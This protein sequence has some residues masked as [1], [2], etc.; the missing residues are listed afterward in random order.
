MK[1]I[2]AKVSLLATLLFCP[3]AF[4]AGSL[5]N[6]VT[7]GTTLNIS[8][9]IPNHLYPNAGIKVNT[10]GYSL[11][12]GCRPTANGYC[13]FPASNTTPAN[14]SINGVAGN[15]ALTLC[16]NGLGPLSC[17]NY[18]TVIGSATPPVIPMH[19]IAY[20]T[21]PAN[22]T[23]SI[24]PVSADGASLGT[25]TLST[26]SGTLN[27]PGF[28][29]FNAAKTYAYITN[30]NNN[31]VSVC[32]VSSTGSL[33][34]CTVTTGNGTFVNPTGIAINAAA[35]FAYVSNGGNDTVSLCPVDANGLLGTCTTSIG[36]HTFDAS[37][38][39]TL[40]TTSNPAATYLYVSSGD[41]YVSICPVNGDG[42]LGTCNIVTGNGTIF[43]PQGVSFNAAGTYAYIAS[44]AANTV[45]VC[46]L[47]NND[48]TFG[49]C[50]TTTGNGTFDF[51]G[52]EAVGLFTS[53]ST[54]YG[55]VPNDGTNTISICPISTIDGS[56]GTCIPTNGNGTFN[57]S[58]S[59]SI[60]SFPLSLNGLL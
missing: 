20:V 17:Q 54:N 5:F 16:L 1:A 29:T 33:G 45:S 9:T 14:L 3:V 57:Q 35:N 28:I 47:N 49:V 15:V 42:S 34:T 51:S 8:T 22:N 43:F 24:C 6:V 2:S 32:P 21:N 38:A 26:G 52:G 59:V 30:L 37:Q 31:S 44:R 56:L 23:I 10:P 25:C 4:S 27:Q 39:I 19:N 58:S 50:I 41:A 11:A 60:N 18:T 40:H 7:T 12:G 53:T 13:L 36:N 46:P 55:Y 48:G